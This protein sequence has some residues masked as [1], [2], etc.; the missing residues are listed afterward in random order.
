M[1]KSKPV[2]FDLSIPSQ[3]KLYLKAQAM[4]NFSSAVRDFVHSYTGQLKREIESIDDLEFSLVVGDEYEY[5]KGKKVKLVSIGRAF[6]TVNYKGSFPFVLNRWEFINKV[7][8][9]EVK[10]END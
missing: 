2:S 6:V 5:E 4:P 9:N 8:L 10:N 7:L 3:K 1:K